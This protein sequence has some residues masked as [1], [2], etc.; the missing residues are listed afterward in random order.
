MKSHHKAALFLL[1]CLTVLFMP[2]IGDFR[3]LGLVAFIYAGLPWYILAVRDHILALRDLEDSGKLKWRPRSPTLFIFGLVAAAM[4]V[5]IDLY[6]LHVAIQNPSSAG[7]LGL[8]VRLLVGLPFFG[9]GAKL[10]HLSLGLSRRG[11]D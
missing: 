5:A 9:L 11:S 2:G 8:L 4:G 7:V 6:L 10:V 3:W 1:V